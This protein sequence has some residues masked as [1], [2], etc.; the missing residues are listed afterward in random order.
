MPTLEEILASLEDE[1]A[2][3][4]RQALAAK[5]KTAAIA[6]RDL[7]L[8]KNNDLKE[9]FPRAW[10]AYS[11]GKLPL[12][13]LVGE[14]ELVDKFKTMESELAELGVPISETPAAQPP[15]GTV[16]PAAAPDPAAAFGA[17][18]SGGAAPSAAHDLE[19]E[20]REAMKSENPGDRVRLIELVDDMNGEQ[21]ARLVDTLN[22]PDSALIRRS[23]G[24]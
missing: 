18:A 22:A 17:S 13:D 4:L 12:G 16:P 3:V 20:F 2:T 10:R 9:R 24:Y 11:K 8:A 14:I 23:R 21:R 1:D 6:K 15:A 19:Q 7:E 5:D